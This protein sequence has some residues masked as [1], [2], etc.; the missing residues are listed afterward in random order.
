MYIENYIKNYFLN[1]PRKT[2]III[3]IISDIFLCLICVILAFYLRIDQ[4]VSLNKPVI[5]AITVSV[6]FALPV[7]WFTRLYRTIFRYSGFSIMFSVSI[8]ILIYGF[9]YFCV[10]T[11]YKVDGVPR[12]IGILQ[13][14]ILFFGIV[15]SRLFVK[16]IFGTISKNKRVRLKIV[17]NLKL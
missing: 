17:L 9:L 8:A 2:K 3:A 13:P 16:L 15:F 12:S 4:I 7:F 14:M 1:L 11:L 10:F 5:I 6:V